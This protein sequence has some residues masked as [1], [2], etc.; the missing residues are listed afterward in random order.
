[1]FDWVLKTPLGIV[2]AIFLA[3]N[4]CKGYTVNDGLTALGA[5][6]K[7][8]AFGW[9]LV[10]IGHFI[11][12]RRYLKKLKKNN[13]KSQTSKLFTKSTKFIQKFYPKLITKIISLWLKLAAIFN[14]FL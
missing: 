1:M 13:K 7:T 11:G 14:W 12:L 3:R 8:K 6:L 10:W 9:A 2:R 4:F 5:F